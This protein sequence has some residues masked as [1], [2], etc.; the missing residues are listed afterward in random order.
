M[1]KGVLGFWAWMGPAWK[2]A[3]QLEKLMPLC[4]KAWG[5]SAAERNMEDWDKHPGWDQ[6]RSIVECSAGTSIPLRLWA[7]GS[8]DA[9]KHK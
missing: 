7:G 9:L 8:L 2:L 6:S 3:A 5:F 1:A 4:H